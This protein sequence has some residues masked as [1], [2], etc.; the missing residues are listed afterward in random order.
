MRARFCSLANEVPVLLPN[1]NRS[2]TTRVFYKRGG[3]AGGLKPPVVVRTTITKD[4]A[5]GRGMGASSCDR[6]EW[7]PAET[8]P[9]R[10]INNLLREAPQDGKGEEP[11]EEEEEEK[12]DPSLHRIQ[13]RG[14]G[15]IKCKTSVVENGMID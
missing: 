4:P 10:A 13:G 1:Q 11:V 15:S 5:S 9:S 14:K 6:R 7:R 8:R 12:K 3:L 2:T